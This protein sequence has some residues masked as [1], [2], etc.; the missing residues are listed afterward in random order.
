M[1]PRCVVIGD[2]GADQ[3]ASLIEIDEPAPVGEIAQASAQL[4]VGRPARAI[5]D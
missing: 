4:N 5:A 1:R 3:P 2:P